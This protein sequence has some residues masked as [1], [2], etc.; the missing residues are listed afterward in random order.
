MALKMVEE[1]RKKRYTV[2]EVRTGGGGNIGTT[3]WR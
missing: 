2:K 3:V 1:M